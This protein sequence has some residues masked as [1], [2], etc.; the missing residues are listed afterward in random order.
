MSSLHV[1]I[2][3]QISVAAGSLVPPFV[4]TFKEWLSKW[5]NKRHQLDHDPSDQVAGIV[6]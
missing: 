4:T 2:S 1:E 6:N 5:A 3:A